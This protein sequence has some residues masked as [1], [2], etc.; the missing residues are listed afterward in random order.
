MFGPFAADVVD[1]V[2][3][4]GYFVTTIFMSLP[5]IALGWFATANVP[6]PPPEPAE[7]PRAKLVSGPEV[8]RSAADP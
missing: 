1:A 3:W 8:A 6:A 4:K 5:G 7:L 2:G